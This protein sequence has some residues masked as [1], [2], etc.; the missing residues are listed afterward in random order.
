MWLKYNAQA[1]SD[2]KRLGII[3]KEGAREYTEYLMESTK[4]LSRNFGMSA[5]QAM[6][7]QETFSKVTGK[8][9]LLTQ[10][11]MEDIA[12]SSKLMGEETVSSAIEMMDNMGSTSQQATELLD[13]NYARAVNSGLDTVKASEAFVK[14]MSLANK[15]T[16]KS[17][18]DGISKMTILSQRIK[19]N[20]QEV[21]NVA[22]KFGS[23]EIGR[24]HV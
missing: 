21:A 4:Q 11:Q 24:A 7:M 17:G 9:S 16:F 8:A 2:A 5:E 3:S 13:K 19:L 15:L 1:I 6:K 23:I 10:A 12:A 18:V 20:L 14:N 22:D